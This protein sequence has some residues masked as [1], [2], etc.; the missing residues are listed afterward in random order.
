MGKTWAWFNGKKTV[1]SA[2]L[3]IICAI[4]ALSSGQS[5]EGFTSPSS[6]QEFTTVIFGILAGGTGGVGLLHKFGKWMN[7][8][9]GEETKS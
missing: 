1:I 9:E 2:I 4:F 6:W 8:D 7:E 5:I 3:W